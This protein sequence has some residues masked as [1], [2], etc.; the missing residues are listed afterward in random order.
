MTTSSDP[1]REITLAVLAGGEGLR[2]GRPKGLLQIHGKPILEWLLEQ[3]QWPG[4]TMLITAPGRE[5]PPGWERFD[6][7]V[8]DPVAGLGPL[9]GVLTGLE[10]AKTELLLIATV[11]MPGI[12]D[13]HLRWITSQIRAS[14]QIGAMCQRTMAGDGAI[15]EPFPLLLRRQA[16]ER[17][18][19]RIASNRL[20]VVGLTEESGFRAVEAP[21]EWPTRVWENLN[22][23]EDLQRFLHDSERA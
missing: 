5:H 11:D 22:R 17:V 12:R 4:P 19:T 10:H 21:T 6:R 1:L 18:W 7:E 20:S 15:I 3:F 16:M 9:R 14:N 13:E 8:C 2:M 23:I